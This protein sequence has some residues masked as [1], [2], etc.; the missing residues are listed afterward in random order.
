MADDPRGAVSMLLTIA[1]TGATLNLATST[2][3]ATCFIQTKALDMGEVHF[4]KFIDQVVSHISDRA[5]Q[6]NMQ[7]AIFGSN[8]EDG[9]FTLEATIV[10]PS[11]DPGNIRPI[12][13][14]YFKLRYIDNGILERWHLHGFTIFGEIGGEEF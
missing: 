9:P 4:T 6:L 1:A 11:V 8:D 7:L 12:A 13:K 14:K 10:L 2:D 5:K 3:S